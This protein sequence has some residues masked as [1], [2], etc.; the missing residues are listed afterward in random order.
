MGSSHHWKHT[1]GIWLETPASAPKSHFGS[2]QVPL[3]SSEV[4]WKCDGCIQELWNISSELD[5]SRLIPTT[6]SLS[7]STPGTSSITQGT[8]TITPGTSISMPGAS[9][10]SPRTSTITSES[11]RSHHHNPLVAEVLAEVKYVKKTEEASSA[12]QSHHFGGILQCTEGEGWA[13]EEGGGEES[14]GACSK[15]G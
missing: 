9:L 12:D 13:G 14:K 7:T 8:T 2:V 10:V 3:R 11:S 4:I 15:R 6:T 1:L 5:A